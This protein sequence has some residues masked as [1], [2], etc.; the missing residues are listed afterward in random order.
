[1][2]STR[3][4]HGLHFCKGMLLRLLPL[5]SLLAALP[6][7]AH[8]SEMKPGEL[9]IRWKKKTPPRPSDRIAGHNIF[10]ARALGN[11]AHLYRIEDTGAQAT[12]AA[13][14]QLRG[15]ADVDFAEPNLVRRP[16]RLPNDPYYPTQWHLKT[17]QLEKA[18]EKTTGS[19]D[20]TVA[21]IDT[22]IVAGHPDLKD[23]LLQ[24]RDFVSSVEDAGDGDGWDADPQDMGDNSGESTAYH[25]THIAGIIG[26]SSDN[27]EGITGVDWACKILPIRVLGVVAGKGSDS[28]IAAAIR[29]AAGLPVPGVPDNPNPARVINLSFGGP[30][31]STVLTEAVLAAQGAGAIVVAAAGNEGEDGWDYYPAAIDGVITVGATQPDGLRAPYSNYGSVLDVMAPGGN[32]SLRLPAPLGDTSA[33]I[34]STLY[35]SSNHAFSYELFEGTSQ[36]APLV[37][38]VVSLMLALNSGLS[39]AEVLSILRHSANPNF[40]CPEGCGAGL[41]DAA[42][43]LRMVAGENVLTDEPTPF[44]FNANCSRDDQCSEGT[45]RD[46]LGTGSFCT[47]RCTAMSDCPAAGADCVSGFCSYPSP[48]QR[49]DRS[50]ACSSGQCLHERSPVEGCSVSL[51]EG[52]SMTPGEGTLLLAGLMV[53]CSRRRR[54]RR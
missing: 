16:F 6:C 36:A 2:L 40:T 44:G 31:S 42:K 9:I 5:F 23:R 53:L 32:L 39:S 30:G 29:W 13:L 38:G 1:L 33:G 11:G 28:D 46:V 18:W 8:E 12:L 24:G 15:R 17:L 35:S 51:T 48:A 52:G 34:L 54:P 43:A 47:L 19:S 21:V 41:I 50:S 45:C 20:V 4:A 25:G 27:N 14:K 3:T 37:A 22:G 10:L 49:A 7:W 26:A